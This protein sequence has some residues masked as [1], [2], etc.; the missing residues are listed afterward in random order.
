MVETTEVKYRRGPKMQAYAPGI[1]DDEARQLF[2][3][4]YGFGPRIVER[5]AGA[6][7]AGPIDELAA[8]VPPKTG[9][10]PLL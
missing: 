4:K 2:T 8:V 1:T 10:M 6:V 9:Q 5:W 7:L 3:A